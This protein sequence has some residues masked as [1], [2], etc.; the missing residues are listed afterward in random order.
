MN[1]DYRIWR[2]FPAILLLQNGVSVSLF[3][4]KASTS[5]SLKPWFVTGFCD[6]ESSFRI[7]IQKNNKF[8]VGYQVGAFFQISVHTKDRVLL[9]LIQSFF[10]V[11]NIYKEHKD[12][13]QYRVNTLKGLNVIV[14][15]FNKYPLITQKWANFEL[16]KQVVDLMNRKEHL[17][18]EG[19][20]QIINIRASINLGLSDKLKTDFPNTKPVN[21]PA[22]EF[23][24][25]PD[26]NWLAGFTSGE[27]CFRV[28]ISNFSSN[29]W[30]VNL[31]LTITQ[32]SRDEQLLK[33]FIKYFSFDERLSESG[34][35]SKYIYKYRD[36]DAVKF[37]VTRY[38][39]IEKIILFF[40][41]YPIIGEKSKD[42]EDFKKV[43]LLMQSKIHLTQEGFEE[44]CKIKLGMN[45]G[46]EVEV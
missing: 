30:G 44:I 41:K 2:N 10:G 7:T 46:R 3:H 5:S 23:K 22:V 26:S 45:R 40:D 28:D 25:I 12:S 43:A 35:K 33:S 21:I 32:H 4:N 36:R 17:T 20:Q 15:H 14:N 16:F 13:I 9:E 11:G 18:K 42:F 31:R 39:D 37:D 19:L 1:K 8:T 34:R 38:S 6:A 29:K 24:G 27:G